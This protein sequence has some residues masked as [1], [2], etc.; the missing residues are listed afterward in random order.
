MKV[1]EP[2]SR[3]LKVYA[4]DPSAGNYVGN[5]MSVQI[6]WERNLKR[7][8][9][10]RRFAVIDYDGANKIYYP[11]VD[12]DD[13]RILARG[14]LD[15]SE[16]EPRFHQQMVYAVAS[17]TLEKFEAALGRTIHWRRA[18]RPGVKVKLAKRKGGDA[19][20]TDDIWVLKL[21]PH[22]MIQANAFYSR[23]A[24][25]VLFGYFRAADDNQGNN[26]PGQRIFTCLS[27]DIIAHEVTHAIIDGI[28][29][30]FTEAT[31]PDVLAF[32]EAFADMTA[33][34][35]H[36]SHKEALLDTIR[37]TGGR[38]YQFELRPDAAPLDG[39]APPRA[40]DDTVPQIVGETATR[41]PLVELAQQF[42]EANFAQQRGYTVFSAEA[43]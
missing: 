14:G 13:Y 1:D 28:R 26:L 19:A 18:D 8:P 38:L 43:E 6:R 40:D 30:F 33:L 36:F 37:K 20:K 7:G 35:L 12:L 17:E 5:V 2:A 31:N 24:H 34:F 39:A 29:A 22:A 41:N 42:G 25:G 15:P 3:S 32:H 21:Y 23:E 4:L 16:S 10:G 11:P 27:H 9:V